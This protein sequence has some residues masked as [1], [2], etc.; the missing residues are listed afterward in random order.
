MR[1]ATSLLVVAICAPACAPKER[2]A[3]DG[4]QPTKV[5]S[6][7]VELAFTHSSPEQGLS[8]T[9]STNGVR[10]RFSCV[11]EERARDS[12]A[13]EPNAAPYMMALSIMNA[14]GDVL[15][16]SGRAQDNLPESGSPPESRE[17]E[18]R[19]VVELGKAL[20]AAKLPSNMEPERRAIVQAAQ[21]TAAPVRPPPV[22]DPARD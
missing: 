21:A 12:L 20:Q 8:G 14:Q 11:R 6:A 15:V 1:A 16:S 2:A 5:T 22:P 7:Q 13:G 19:A 9:F 10:I 17:A 4:P 18:L 3:I